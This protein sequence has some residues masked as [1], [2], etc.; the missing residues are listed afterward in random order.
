MGFFEVLIFPM[1]LLSL[2]IACKKFSFV[3]FYLQFFFQK[4]IGIGG[5]GDMKLTYG[6]RILGMAIRARRE[7]KVNL[8]LLL[9]FYRENQ[10]D[11]QY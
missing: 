8:L 1:M 4:K 6:T 10:L 9:F 2:L 7:S 5:V 11:L 3:N